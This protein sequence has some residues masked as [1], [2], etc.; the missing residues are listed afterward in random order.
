[1][2]RDFE[3]PQLLE[4]IG[5]SAQELDGIVRDVVRLSEKISVEEI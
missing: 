1:M 2:D 4:N 5:S 3:L